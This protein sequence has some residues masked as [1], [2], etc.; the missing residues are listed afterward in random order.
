MVNLDASDLIP[1]RDFDL[2]WRIT[3]PRWAALPEA[4]LARFRPL[5][6]VRARGLWA[7]AR[8][9]CRDLQAASGLGRSPD[10]PRGV[11]RL[12]VTREQSLEASGLPDDAGCRDW[13]R[14]LPINLDEQVYLCWNGDDGGVAAATNWG[15]FLKHWED[16]WYPFDELVVFDETRGW[17]V[18]FGPEEAVRYA[19]Q[20]A[21]Q[22][23]A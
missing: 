20:M 23:V 9:L 12:A 3:D 14:V 22:V 11:E 21:Q 2:A 4:D 1:L 19:E 17:A 7:E 13:F 15:T 6:R 10:G 5:S 16:L 8:D 18:L